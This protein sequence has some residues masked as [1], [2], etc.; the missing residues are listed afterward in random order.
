M[1]HS[2]S[3]TII[4]SSCDIS[5]TASVIWAAPTTLEIYVSDSVSVEGDSDV[6]TEKGQK[7]LPLTSTE[8]LAY[9]RELDEVSKRLQQLSV[10]WGEKNPPLAWLVKLIA[11]CLVIK[12][13]NALLN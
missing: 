12:A 2:A 10:E 1:D 9:L 5:A 4:A 8:L 7:L 13:I 6:K 11:A 3:A